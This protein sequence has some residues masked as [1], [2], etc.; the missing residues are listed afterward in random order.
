M[1]IVEEEIV[2]K[3]PSARASG[4]PNA[5]T[6]K[7][8]QSPFN[9]H[10]DAPLT[11]SLW[12]Y[13]E[14]DQVYPTLTFITELVTGIPN[15][16]EYVLDLNS[17]PEIRISKYDFPFGFIGINHTGRDF[18]PNLWSKPLPLAWY[19]NPYWQREYGQNWQESFCSSWFDAEMEAD[20]FALTVF[21]CPCTVEQSDY[22]RGR[23][24]PDV[25]CNVIDKKCEN[26]HHG[27]LHC[28]RTARPS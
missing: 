11:I 25:Q 18:T 5:L 8:N 13:K 24:A 14:E 19:M 4:D 1:Q 3:L 20:R 15:T 27:A 6:I 7:W 10:N 26:L 12:G 2:E 16:G 23:F 17:L 22:D 21:R 28:V 9:W